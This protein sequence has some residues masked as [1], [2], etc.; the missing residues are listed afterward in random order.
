[1]RD[2][3]VVFLLLGALGAAFSLGLSGPARAAEPPLFTLTDPRGDDHGDGTVTYPRRTDLRQG[4]LD[5]LSLVARPDPEGTLFEAT[6]ARPI[7][8][9]ESQ[10]IDN[11]GTTADKVAR[12]GFY[13]FNLDIYI[14]TDRLPGS[15]SRALLP[16]RK[17]EVDPANAWEKAICLTP[18]PYEAKEGLK[19]L[20]TRFARRD[21]KAQK[22]KVDPGD[23]KPTEA[24]ISEDVD[25]KVFFPTR[26]RV[27][28]PT[29]SFL[30]PVSFLGGRAQTT[31]SYVVA[32]S[33][34][35]I[36]QK[37]DAPGLLGLSEPDPDSLMI[38]PVSYSNYSDRF[39]TTRDDPLLP[40]IIDIIV[41]P[42]KKQEEVLKDDDPKSGRLVRLPGVVPAELR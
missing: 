6:F 5:L 31:W 35:D 19:R 14:D 3:R 37:I 40:P 38:M 36:I 27:V 24:G 18:R 21:L 33:G 26:V 23:M 34:A 17:A 15:G 9:P 39:A 30:V 8:R 16:G 11:L 22:G 7:A 13:T 1:M 4:D 42:G 32:V 20:L 2:R 29:V 10:V 28:G 12:F 41:P 25:K